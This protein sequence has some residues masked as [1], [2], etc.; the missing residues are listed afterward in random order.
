MSYYRTKQSRTNVVHRL[1]V[2]TVWLSDIDIQQLYQNDSQSNKMAVILQTFSNTYFQRKLVCFNHDFR[3]VCCSGPIYIGKHWFRPYF[4]TCH[5]GYGPDSYSKLCRHTKHANECILERWHSMN[6]I[7]CKYN[8][9]HYSDVIMSAMASQITGVST[10]CSIV[11]SGAEQKKHQSSASVGF[12]RG[13]HK[14][15]VVG[16][17]KGPETRKML[18]FDDVLMHKSILASYITSF[19]HFWC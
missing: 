11:C 2:I 1:D 18:P 9:V 6:N 13:I 8:T 7:A 17:H 16:P 3:E 15:P 14:W 19:A 5:S 10:V 12:V 4:G